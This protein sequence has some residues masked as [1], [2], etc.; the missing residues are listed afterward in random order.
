MLD[1]AVRRARHNFA[2]QPRLQ[3]ELLGELGR[4]YGRLGEWVAARQVLT[5]ALSI[6]ERSAPPDDAARNKAEVHLADALLDDGEN[7]RAEQLALRVRTAC[8]Q[9]DTECAKAR[10]YASNVLGKLYLSRGQID[11]SLNAMRQSVRDT[12]LG[13]G[14][15]D[16]ETAMALMSLA[17]IARN[18]GHL[19]EAGTAMARALDVAAGETMRSA[20]RVQLARTAAVLDFDLGRYAS[21]NQ[22]LTNLLAH[23]RSRD[24][25]ALQQR[26]LANVQLAQGD[27]V[28]AFESAEAAIALAD[29]QHPDVEVLFARQVRAQSLAGLRRPQAALSEI[30]AVIE[31][32]GELGWSVDSPEVLRARRIRGEILLRAGTTCRESRGAA[33]TRDSIEASAWATRCGTGADTRSHGT[34]AGGTRTIRRGDGRACERTGGP[35]GTAAR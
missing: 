5:E 12:T 6:L 7:M 34:R 31:G 4:M 9:P 15:Q 24:E 14:E 10:A 30:Q 19:R 26:L 21:A 3:G 1:G 8:A 32:L 2:E 29:S 20:D 23:T 27:S 22:R 33:A 28:A 13:F 16:P 25:R 17:I 35:R 18:A 11:E